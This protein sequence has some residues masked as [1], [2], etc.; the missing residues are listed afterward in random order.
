[1]ATAMF[2]AGSVAAIHGFVLCLGVFNVKTSKMSHFQIYL[3]FLG[4][5]SLDVEEVMCESF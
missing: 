4:G 1:M 3:W 5:M 2:I